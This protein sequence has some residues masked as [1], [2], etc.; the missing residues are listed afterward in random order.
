MNPN[1]LHNNRSCHRFIIALAA[2]VVFTH[3][4][5]MMS[6]CQLPTQCWRV[7]ICV[8]VHTSNHASA[9]LLVLY[10]RCVYVCACSLNP[11]GRDKMTVKWNHIYVYNVHC[12][13][14]VFFFRMNTWF[15]SLIMAFSAVSFQFS[16]R[17]PVNIWSFFFECEW[18]EY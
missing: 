12:N 18:F 17:S 10:V 6:V 7:R 13:T 9:Y 14:I 2:F 8:F 3:V 15:V 16:L 11:C 1:L 5:W 4:I